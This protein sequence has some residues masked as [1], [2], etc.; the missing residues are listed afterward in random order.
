MQVCVISIGPSWA[1]TWLIFHGRSIT[2]MSRRYYLRAYILILW[3]EQSFHFAWVWSIGFEMSFLVLH[4]WMCNTLIP[5]C[6]NI[7]YLIA[8][9]TPCSIIFKEVFVYLC[10]AKC[11]WIHILYMLLIFLILIICTSSIKYPHSNAIQYTVLLY[12]KVY[13]LN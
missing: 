1:T 3:V 11:F 4:T 5:I 7:F 2:V 12:L 9:K 8:L 6:L 10:R 13:W